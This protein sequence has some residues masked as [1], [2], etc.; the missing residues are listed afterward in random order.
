MSS[1]VGFKRASMDHGFLTLAAA[2]GFCFSGV[3][4]ARPDIHLSIHKFL[5]L[6]SD[7]HVRID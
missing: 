5:D 2:A 4:A 3:E 1:P 7:Y 6:R